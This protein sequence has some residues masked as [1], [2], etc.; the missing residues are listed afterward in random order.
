M[1]RTDLQKM[2]ELHACQTL[3]VIYS[4]VLGSRP[5][6]LQ[7]LSTEDIDKLDVFQWERS[8]LET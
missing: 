3:L 8:I 5:S 2:D 7:F 1:E 4:N 6:G